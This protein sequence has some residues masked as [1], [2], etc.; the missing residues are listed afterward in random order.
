MGVIRGLKCALSL[1]GLCD[2]RLCEPIERCDAA[3]RGRIAAI[4][5][6]LGLLT[7]ASR[8]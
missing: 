2:D 6:Q 1:A 8:V 3:A 5:E 4:V 7:A